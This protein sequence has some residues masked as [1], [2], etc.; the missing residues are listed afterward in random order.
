MKCLQLS[1]SGRLIRGLL[2]H[3][4]AHLVQQEGVYIAWALIIKPSGIVLQAAEGL[5]CVKCVDC[6]L[7]SEIEV[8]DKVSRQFGGQFVF[9][10]LDLLRCKSRCHNF[11]S[12]CKVLNL[13]T[14]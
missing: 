14:V 13:L 5:R 2:D 6:F 11:V 10:Q 8:I 7:R 1:Q 3:G 9:E 12:F 4:T